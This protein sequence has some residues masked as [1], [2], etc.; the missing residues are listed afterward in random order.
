[1]DTAAPLQNERIVGLERELALT[2]EQL[3][4]AQSFVFGARCAA[5]RKAGRGLWVKEMDMS[6]MRA[7]VWGETEGLGEWMLI[8]VSPFLHC[9]F[10][11][12]FSMLIWLRIPNL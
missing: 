9:L 3:E 4:Q 6:G 2:R 5:A 12:L 7:G 11:L 8:K 1:M 10:L